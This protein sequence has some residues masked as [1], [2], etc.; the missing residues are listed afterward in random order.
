VLFDLRKVVCNFFVIVL[1]TITKKLREF[2]Y[3]DYY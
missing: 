3:L 1:R 2:N